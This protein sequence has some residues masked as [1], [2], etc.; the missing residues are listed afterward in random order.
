M[1]NV[2]KTVCLLSLAVLVAWPLL[3]QEKEKKKKDGAAKPT[4]KMVA[5]IKENVDLTEEQ[6]KKL[7]ELAAKYDE[8]IVAANKKVGADTMKEINA[9]KKAASAEGKK[10]KDL[11][12]AVDAAVKLTDEQKAGLKEANDLQAAF[13]QEAAALLTPE[14]AEKAGLTKKKKKDKAA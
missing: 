10:G 7:D 4:A 2:W 14:Q 8:K 1:K 13:R 6:G 11:Q 9:A 12:A 5:N 3:A